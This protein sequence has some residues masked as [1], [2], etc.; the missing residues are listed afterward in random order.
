M[1]PAVER[2]QRI[3]DKGHLATVAPLLADVLYA[4]GRGEEAVALIELA[5]RWVIEDDLDPQ[6]GWRRVQAKLLAQRGDFAEAERLGREA[7]G[8][9]E[10]TDFLD[11]RARAHEDL[12]EVLR[13]AGQHEAASAEL[14]SAIRLHDQKGNLVS[15][16]RARTL[17]DAAARAV[18]ARSGARPGV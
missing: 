1:R 11:H 6:I 7:A 5:S 16:A 18:S 9:A 14:D 4:Q 17:R 15:A 8:I 12:A 13:L 10:R 2:L 3:G